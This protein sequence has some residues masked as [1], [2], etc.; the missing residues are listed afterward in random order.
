[1]AKMVKS[2]LVVAAV[3]A[4]VELAMATNYTVGAPSGSWNL[5][6]NL[7]QWAE[8]NTFHVGDVLS[9]LFSST[10]L[11]EISKFYTVHKKYIFLNFNEIYRCI[12][13]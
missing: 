13:T 3:V 4:V 7:T 6:T 2:L 12:K 1:M 11:N 9:K 10:I 5:Q 8:S